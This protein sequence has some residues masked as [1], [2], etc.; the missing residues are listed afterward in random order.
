MLD[1]LFS[2]LRDDAAT[3]DELREAVMTLVETERI[4]RRVLGGAHPTMTG[5]E[6]ALEDA[7]VMLHCLE[8][9]SGRSSGSA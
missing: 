4:A 7:R 8:M 3:L 2:V 6:E 1:P 5:I 9:S